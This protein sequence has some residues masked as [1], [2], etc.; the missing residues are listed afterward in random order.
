STNPMNWDS[1]G[2]GL[3][4]GEEVD[5]GSDPTSHENLSEIDE[6]ENG[7]MNEDG[8]PGFSILHALSVLVLVALYRRRIDG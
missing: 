4:D 7:K 6:E 8:V 3:S 2:D 5:R 1:D